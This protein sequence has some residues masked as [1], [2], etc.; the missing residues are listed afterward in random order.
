MDQVV[1]DY[2]NPDIP[3]GASNPRRAAGARHAPIARGLRRDRARSQ[4]PQVEIVPWPVEGRRK[5]DPG[6]GDEGGTTE[7]IFACEWRGNELRGVKPRRWA[8]TMS[9]LRNADAPAPPV[10]LSGIA[11]TIP[12]AGSSSGRSTAGLSS[13]RPGRRATTS[14]PERFVAFWSDG[15]FGIYHPSRR[16]AR[17]SVPGDAD[18]AATSTSRARCTRRVSCDLAREF[19]LMLDVPL[20]TR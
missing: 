12:T 19:G 20:P 13:C 14:T 2:L 18:A 15:S 1:I 8:E 7:G 3:A 5:L 17:G 4:H 10:D 9:G 6:T 11:T 16:L